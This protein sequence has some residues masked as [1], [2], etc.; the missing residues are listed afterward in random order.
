MQPFYQDKKIS[1]I[2]AFSTLDYAPH[3]HNAL[4]IGWLQEGS[5]TLSL[6]RKEFLI[7][8]GDLF[9]IF[10]HFIHAFFESKDAK[11]LLAIL[12]WEDLSPFHGILAEQMPVNPIL[13]K[14]SWEQSRLQKLFPL[15]AE[16]NNDC[17]EA[18]KKGY[19]RILAGKFLSL[20]STTQR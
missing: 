8:A 12:T 1:R 2:S 15:A 19:C 4:E 7:K 10:P 14:G 13:P 17:T 18:V 20:V 16:E 9:I 3:L 6:E 5:G 11:G